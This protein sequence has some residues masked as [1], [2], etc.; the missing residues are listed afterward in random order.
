M[1]HRDY[2]DSVLVTIQ[3]H[4]VETGKRT[5]ND[6]SRL[7]PD[8]QTSLEQSRFLDLML[9]ESTFKETRSSHRHFNSTCYLQPMQAISDTRAHFRF[10]RFA[11][12]VQRRD[13]CSRV[14]V[15]SI[16]ARL[17][18][19]TASRKRLSCRRNCSWSFSTLAFVW[20]QLFLGVNHC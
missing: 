2:D 13:A 7:V 14:S 16:S 10:L 11:Y 3:N 4:P 6:Y 17:D 18:N 20:K 9:L 8:A 1:P 19:L 15:R 12:P 5:F